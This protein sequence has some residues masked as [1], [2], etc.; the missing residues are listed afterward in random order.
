MT[1]RQS[2]TTAISSSFAGLAIGAGFWFAWHLLASVPL[3][4]AR[5]E[6]LAAAV[7]FVTAL[8]MQFNEWCAARQPVENDGITFE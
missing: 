1:L 2:A 4:F 3:G 5:S 8:V 6:M 7:A